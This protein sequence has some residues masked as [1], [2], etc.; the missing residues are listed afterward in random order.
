MK[1]TYPKWFMTAVAE[2]DG[3][4]ERVELDNE[5]Y[6]IHIV[7]LQRALKKGARKAP[8]RRSIPPKPEPP[9]DEDLINEEIR[10][11][12]ALH[13]QVLDSID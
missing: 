11:N 12:E 7:D 1:K 3:E 10:I 2:L 6:Q 8:K 9:Q 4:L 13:D 5:D